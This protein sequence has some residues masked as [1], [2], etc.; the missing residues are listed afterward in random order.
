MMLYSIF[1]EPAHILYVRPSNEDVQKFSKKELKNLLDGSP[2]LRG[3]FKENKGKESSNTI[4]QKL[5]PGGSLTLVGSGSA[6]ALAGFSAKIVLIDEVDKMLPI[7]GV[8]NVIDLA[9]TRSK[10]F[11][12]YGRKLIYIST[13][14]ISGMPNTVE[15]LY[16][17]KS[18]MREWFSPCPYCGEY[19]VVK[20]E[21]VKYGHCTKTL[22]DIYIECTACKGHIS[23]LQRM[24]MVRKGE[25]RITNHDPER[26]D[27]PGFWFSD[28][29]SPFSSLKAIVKSWLDVGFDQLKL[30]NFINETLGEAW[31]QEIENKISE[32]TLYGR[33]EVYSHRIPY[34]VGMLTA[35][36]DVQ[37]NRLEYSLWGWGASDECW[38][39]EHRIIQ[40]SPGLREVWQTLDKVIHQTYEHESG[41]LMTIDRVCVDTG[42]HFT[43]MVYNYCHRKHPLIVPIKGSGQPGAPL[44]PAKG[45]P[46][47]PRNIIRFDLGVDAIKD[48]LFGYLSNAE[49]G[50]GFVHFPEHPSPEHPENDLEYFK[51]LTAEAPAYKFVSGQKTKYYKQIRARNEALDC[52]CY[53]YGGFKMANFNNILDAKLAALAYKPVNESEE[54]LNITVETRTMPS[55]TPEKQ[56]ET[57]KPQPQAPIQT[58]KPY[59]YT[60][61]DNSNTGWL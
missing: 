20:W 1:Q 44:I 5:F 14:E 45:T 39:I 37:D 28:L 33:R 2:K 25:W 26:A 36:V 48:Q 32:D 11:A 13:P 24:P 18:D 51:Q 38:L 8:G 34:G 49:E 15:D 27:F 42:G 10:T 59:L 6:G 3:F 53:A 23:E 19:Q 30:K 54:K 43:S 4:K 58:P 40:G 31:K 47:G 21:N 17:N 7:P 41:A 61:A 55:P 12:G 50:P 60:L 9:E 29:I 46:S 57:P 35:G 22:D 56:Q 52:F 16:Y